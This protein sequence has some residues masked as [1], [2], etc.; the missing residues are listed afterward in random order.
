MKGVFWLHS[1]LHL[2][3]SGIF[4]TRGRLCVLAGSKLNNTTGGGS[5]QQQKIM[6]IPT[7]NR[8]FGKDDCIGKTLRITKGEYKGHL[9]QI[10]ESD[11]EKYKVELLSKMKKITIE[12]SKTVIIGDKEGSL[13]KDRRSEGIFDVSQ[14]VPSTPFYTQDTP[15][16]FATNA[17]PH[18]TGNETP[19]PGGMTPGRTPNAYLDENIWGVEQNAHTV[20]ASQTGGNGSAGLSDPWGMSPGHGLDSN[21][22]SPYPSTPGSVHGGDTPAGNRNNSSGIT[23][24]DWVSYSSV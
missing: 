22:Q 20:S 10:F 16:Y 3:N 19:G 11:G 24:K 1:N 23:Y 12:K 8:R 6:P 18:Y 13:E 17:T 21:S 2:K 15:H 9:G 5:N 14:A 4:V 7:H